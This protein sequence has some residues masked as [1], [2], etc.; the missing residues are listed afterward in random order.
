VWVK[1]VY[2][3]PQIEDTYINLSN[4]NV[5]LVFSGEPVYVDT[6]YEDLPVVVQN[7]IK[8]GKFW[9]NRDQFQK[10][11]SLMNMPVN[12]F[13]RAA[14]EDVYSAKAYFLE[15]AK[16]NPR[17]IALWIDDRGYVKVVAS[18]EYYPVKHST[19]AEIIKNK[20]IMANIPLLSEKPLYFSFENGT[21][22]LYKIDEDDHYEYYIYAF[23]RNDA[24]HSIKV[25]IALLP[26][27]VTAPEKPF[28]MFDRIEGTAISRTYHIRETT[29]ERFSIDVSALLYSIRKI[30]EALDNLSRM[31]IDK[32][33]KKKVKEILEKERLPQYIAYKIEKLMESYNVSNLRDLLDRIAVVATEAKIRNSITT[34]TKIMILI[35]K[36]I[37]KMLD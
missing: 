11:L 34:H 14:R 17:T 12:D 6:K 37:E 15:K 21:Y 28:M 30:K 26:K 32:E 4:F 35:R 33:T 19:I 5:L 23:N 20:L 31:P 36:I 27:W 10:V 3:T 9:L 25:G 7:K 8:T 18:E 29:L 24:R 1:L 13:K 2:E 22:I 16:E